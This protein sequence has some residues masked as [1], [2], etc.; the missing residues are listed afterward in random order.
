MQEEQ[1]KVRNDIINVSTTKYGVIAMQD[2]TPKLSSTPG[3]VNWAGAPLGAFNEEVLCKILGYT[4]QKFDELKTNSVI[5]TAI[6]P[7][8]DDSC[9]N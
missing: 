7:Q 8:K 6:N 5:Y 9:N 4:Q 1:F 2:V 3:R